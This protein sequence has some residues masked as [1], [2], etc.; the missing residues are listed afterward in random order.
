LTFAIHISLESTQID[1][2]PMTT[3]LSRTV[4]EIKNIWQFRS[5]DRWIFPPTRVF[6]ASA[7]GVPSEIL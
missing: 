2:L 3:H 4:S 7:E 1:R 5:K 6:N